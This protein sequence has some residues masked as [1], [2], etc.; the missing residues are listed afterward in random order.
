MKNESGMD[1]NVATS[2]EYGRRGLLSLIQFVH[3]RAARFSSAAPYK[4]G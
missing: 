3:Q 4:V 2:D 1:P